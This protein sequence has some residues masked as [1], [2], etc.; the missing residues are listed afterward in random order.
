MTDT[1]TQPTDEALVAMIASGDRSAIAQ[2]YDRH[3]RLVFGLA[4]RILR[5]PELCEEAVQD[6]FLK[7][8]RGADA[9]DSAR[10]SVVTWIVTIARNCAIDRLRK[11]QAQ[12]LSSSVQLLDSDTDDA[13]SSSD[14]TAA[15]SAIAR[16]PADIAAGRWRANRIRSA[17]DK[18]PPA[19][20]VAIELSYFGGLSQSEIAQ[21]LDEP[22]GTVKTRMF[23]GMRKLRDY[24][25][26]A[27]VRDV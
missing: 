5:E 17:V 16:D 25:E 14:D 22:L 20:R 19:Q 12:P 13:H 6:T 9:Y 11:E 2:L 21:R 4:M 10:A 23:H 24:L 1:A 8:W 3:G 26:E 7:V 15:G 18:L 27:G